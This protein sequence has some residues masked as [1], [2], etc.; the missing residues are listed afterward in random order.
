MHTNHVEVSFNIPFV[1][2]P[3]LKIP[4]VLLISYSEAQYNEEFLE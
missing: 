4:D 3:C 1:A 2:L